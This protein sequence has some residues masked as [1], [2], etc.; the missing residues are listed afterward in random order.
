M[1]KSERRPQLETLLATDLSISVLGPIVVRSG[2]SE[3]DLG[4][5]KQRTVLAMLVA[6][7]GDFVGAGKILTAV[8]GEDAPESHRRSLQTYVSNLRAL[9][10]VQIARAGDGYRLEIDDSQVDAL[11]F[12]NTLQTATELI[13]TDP[14]T[15]SDQLRQALGLWRGRPY[16]DVDEVESLQWE[17][18][19][20][21]DLRLS[22]VE[23]RVDAD[24]AAGRHHNILPE[25]GA[26]AEEHPLREKFRAQH[27]LAL[28]RSG[29]QAEALRAFQRTK[30]YLAEEMGI[31]PSLELQ[32]LELAI[33][34][35][36]S[37][38]ESG[39]GRAT[40]QRLAF[41][42]T[43]I[44][45]ST[46]MW[47]HDPES[48]S[49]AMATHDRI[50][51]EVVVGASGSVHRQTGEGTVAVFSDTITAVQ[52]AE[53]TQKELAMAGIGPIRARM[54]IDV[55]EAEN[56]S[57]EFHGPPL[58]RAAM[59]SA[60]AHGGQ[61][62][63]S[64]R[65]QRDVADSSPAGLQ[66][67]H[68]GEH[69]LRGFSSPER[70]GQL[71]ID[72]LP[73]DFPQLRLEPDPSLEPDLYMSLPGYELRERIGAGTF[74]VVHKA[75]QPSV[76]REVAV[77]IIRPQLAEH[78]QF[79][80]RYEAEARN[81]ARL[82]H[83]R[84]VPLIDFWRDPDGAYLV[85]QLLSGGSLEERIAAGPIDPGTALGMIHHIAEAIAHAHERGVAHGD[86][87][88]ANVLLDE[89][90]NA[91][92]SDFAI[93]ARLL[94]PEVIGS[95]SAASP[96]RA[97]EESTTGPSVAADVYALGKIT[98]QI[99]DDPAADAVVTRAIATNPDDRYAGVESFL[100][101]LNDAL[102]VETEAVVRPPTARNPYKGLRPFEE[103]DKSDYYGR[104]DLL[105]SLLATIEQHRFV[106]LV[107][108]SGSG[109][110]SVIRAGLLPFLSSG[111]IPGSEHWLITIFTP[112]THPLESL[113]E[114][115]RA[116]APA[117]LDLVEVLEE[118]GLNEVA[119]RFQGDEADL[120]LVIDQFEELFAQVD[121]EKKIRAFVELLADSVTD[122]DSQVRVVTTL[123]ADFYD[124]PLQ[125]SGLDHLYRDGHVMMLRPTREEL[126]QMISRPAHAVGLHWEP[127]L[128]DRIAEEIA[129]QPGGLPLLQYALTEMVEKR[130][131]DLLTTE[132]Y[133]RVGGVAGAL[134]SRAEAAFEGLTDEQRQVC[135]EVF[136]RL[137][138]VDEDAEDTRRRVRRS[139]LEYLGIDGSD[140]TSVL[141]SFVTERLLLVDRDPVTRGPT[142]EVAHE[143]LLKEWPRLRNWIDDQREALLTERK[144]R[145]ARQEWISSGRDPDYL[146]T[147]SRLAPYLPWGET[148]SLPPDDREYL[149]ASKH[150]DNQRQRA[151]QRRRRVLA[152]MFGSAAVIALA[153]AAWAFGERNRATEQAA[154]ALLAEE[155]AETQAQLAESEA[156]RAD[157]NAELARSRELAASAINVLD[158]DPALSKLLAM[159]ATDI[160]DPPIESVS[161][162]HR[163][164]AS[165]R[166][167][168]R[169]F[170][171]EGTPVPWSLW[172]DIHPSGERL[173]AAGVNGLPLSDFY[174]HIEV[175]EIST[176]DVIWQRD[177]EH[178]QVAIDRPRFT[179]DGSLVVGAGLWEI[180]TGV[181]E[182]PPAE[183]VGV[184]VWDADTGELIDRLDFGPCGATV[185]D[186]S[187]H[188]VLVRSINTDGPPCWIPGNWNLELIDLDTGDRQLLS[189]SAIQGP[190]IDGGAAFSGDGRFVAFD[191]AGGEKV[192][193]IDTVTGSRTAEL[194]L[195]RAPNDFRS[196][197]RRLNE[198]G[199]LLVYGQD[200]IRIVDVSTGAVITEIEILENLVELEGD[201]LYVTS[202]EGDLHGFDIRTGEELFVVAQVGTGNISPL[203]ADTVLVSNGSTGSGLVDLGARGEVGAVDTCAGYTGAANPNLTA[204]GGFALFMQACEDD[205][206]DPILLTRSGAVRT[207]FV[208]DVRSRQL[209]YGLPDAKG[210]ALAI[211]PDGTRFVRQEGE[212]AFLAGPLM[213]RDLQTG[214]PL[215]EL[216]GLC[217]F[218]IYALND[219]TDC[220]DFSRAPFANWTTHLRWSPDGSMIA[221]VHLILQGNLGVWDAHTGE[222]LFIDA[223]E[224]ELG[225]PVD[226]IFTPD[227]SGLIVSYA[228]STIT[229][230]STETWDI[231]QET[232]IDAGV[233]GSTGL[234]FIGHEP[235]Q[236]QL[237]AIS[238][239][240]PFLQGSSGD[241]SLIWLDAT[242][243]EETSRRDN[244]HIAD[245]RSRALSEDGSLVATGSSTGVV[246]VWDA[247]SGELVHEVALQSDAIQGVAFV[248]DSHLAVT[249]S[250]GDLLIVTIDTEELLGIARESL[251]RGF[252]PVEC[253]RF[254]FGDA[255]PSL[256]E[257]RSP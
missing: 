116:V 256:E 129:D 25:I 136:L 94:A 125:H 132:D 98:E 212:G 82:T 123:R 188:R 200:P 186:L 22:A 88:P 2:G 108:A 189:T 9:L 137:V 102:S 139:E 170:W 40:T 195:T 59:L 217:W 10:D 138:Q 33:L 194:E 83:P 168:A 96:F 222:L 21:E 192:I 151:R 130:R 81:I 179:S 140:L 254:N 54:G 135:R 246:R 213:V 243:L 174:A 38:L 156:D 242:T 142:V 237:I 145:A 253:E 64:T 77:K 241:S 176:G 85:L 240:D 95:V 60:A 221:V 141:D 37:E 100:A 133:E 147:G 13:S 184:F 62:L 32:E 58:R 76:G 128:P 162:L 12:D 143:A 155:R 149:E 190:G 257:L 228:G 15:A 14:Q 75:Y 148:A 216:E 91:Y 113:L 158:S 39:T 46:E 103:S 185:Q 177:F 159:A 7:P 238:G 109:K 121:D 131:G 53:R 220:I 223:G 69:R 169:Y 18:R 1:S 196:F 72:G 219:E 172:T 84:I 249:P 230:V 107:G 201:T 3:I 233:T 80:Q 204:G 104:D 218:D 28:Y 248:G 191:D 215:V 101:D 119:R 187:D 224:T 167:V 126:I 11:V 79:I 27:M 61:V 198:T 87:K 24:L 112:G 49:D 5:P 180:R 8:W 165:D 150:A 120:V 19:R 206:V 68:L 235:R 110:S 92:V 47:D 97:P 146:L 152:A 52:A 71:V 193:I 106:T 66:I 50:V 6:N 57:G 183:E 41:L 127:H 247:I 178:P 73:G 181:G 160:S 250:K 225:R 157:R 114:A 245:V 214:E 86:L 122:P 202:A 227:S 182:A 163:A 63:L 111:E 226:S 197:V 171:P 35:Q 211:S 23:A 70:I 199:D 48:M 134:S 34:Q 89:A 20:L 118:G 36:D 17:I 67:R 236:S 209:T 115:L 234:S 90:G 244:I 55:G 251:T 16:S 117:K 208:V 74:G 153:L 161:A 65:A 207:S 229:R 203:D 255:C 173:V 29:R 124:G 154:A 56:R 45:D 239:W 205:Q 166:V 105:E 231:E 26:L 31:E 252:S 43:R 4:G 144:F 78:P 51:G 42:V 175:V 30:D 44:D 164:L 99:L 232:A 93:A 210:E